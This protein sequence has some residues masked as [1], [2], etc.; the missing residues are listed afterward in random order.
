MTSY[1]FLDRFPV[2]ILHILFNYIPIPEL[3]YNLYNVSDYINAILIHYSISLINLKSFLQ[4]HVDFIC[5]HIKPDQIISLKLFDDIDNN[6]QS[7]LFFSH[8]HIEQFTQLQSLTLINIENTFLEFILPN[9]NRLNHLRSFSFDTTEDYR[10][11]NKDYRLRF[12]QCK[13][14]LLNT[15]T[16]LLSQLKQLTLYNVQ[17][18]TL[19][20]L[21]CLHHLKI[22]ECSTTELKRICSEIPQL[23][24]FN[25]CLQG[26][27]IYIKDLSSL[28][29]LTWLILKIDV[30]KNQFLSMNFIEE[31][32]PNLFQLKHFEFQ[33][34]YGDDFDDGKRWEKL[35]KSLITFNFKFKLRYL[36][37]SLNSF[38]TS[39]WLEEKHWFVVYHNGDL[40]TI[41]RFV[42]IQLNINIPLSIM[43][44]SSNHTIF[45]ENITKL[46]VST[47]IFNENH[48]F[49]NVKILKMNC[50]VSIEKLSHIINLNEI[51]HL[52]LSSQN[53]VRM[54]L[55]ILPVMP[56]FNELTITGY[57]VPV[58]IQELQNNI[59]K[60]IRI[61]NLRFCYFEKESISKTLCHIFPCIEY[62]NV[63]LINSTE[64][65]VFFTKQLKYLLN[66]SFGMNS[67]FKKDKNKNCQELQMS[68]DKKYTCQ[69]VHS[70][71][72]NTLSFVHIWNTEHFEGMARICLFDLL[73]IELLQ[74][75]FSYFLA[76]EIFLSFIDVSDYVNA[77]LLSY[78]AYQLDLKLIE[79]SQLNSFFYC[80]RPEQIISLT[81]SHD[82]DTSHLSIYFLSIFRLEQF[83]RL[84]SITFIDIKYEL[85][86]SIFNNLHKLSQLRSLSF[87][88]ENIKYKY[89]IFNIDFPAKLNQLN[90]FLFSVFVQILPHL[91]RVHL[92]NG[93]LLKSISLPHLHHLKLKKCSLNQL[94]AIF[95]HTPQLK[96]LDVCLRFEN[97][98]SQIV[99]SSVQLIRLNLTI[100]NYSVSINQLEQ[101]LLNLPYLKHFEVNANGRN[102][103]DGQQWQILTR[104]LI[105]F[106]FKFNTNLDLNERTLHSFRTPYWLE[107]KHW[108]VAYQNNCLFT[109]SR[110]ASIHM[111]IS[112]STYVYTTAPNITYV[113]ESITKL[114][115]EAI[116]T[117]N[118]IRYTHIEILNLQCSIS[119]EELISIIDLRQVKH[120]FILSLVDLLKLMPFEQLLPRICKL[121]ILNDLTMDMIKQIRYY[122][123]EQI[124]E[125]DISL[126]YENKNY[127]MKKIVYV[128]PFIE[129]ISYRNYL[130]S[131][132]DMF[133]FIYGFEHLR[134]TYFYTYLIFPNIARNIYRNPEFPIDISW[135]FVED[136]DFL[137]HIFSS[138]NCRQINRSIKVSVR[139]TFTIEILIC[140]HLFIIF[141]CCNQ[142][143]I[144]IGYNN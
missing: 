122:Q 132:Q 130:H 24:S 101:L 39:F 123:F 65:I 19:K 144:F 103:A 68:I 51:K 120:L 70:L 115:I 98:F 43:S 128:F 45:Y 44:N 114:T 31:F 82:N 141:R 72:Y 12:T 95:Q 32:L 109:V 100:E 85:I 106:N 9:L 131:I 40:Y 78:A 84:R 136:N 92:N 2:E 75:I 108:F 58:L 38:R 17:E 102:L 94:E 23:K 25:A 127:I 112:S 110:I 138:S 69:I 30:F 27:P 55:L 86:E 8:F 20:S 41:P 83:I 11:I 18:M 133:R 37:E 91:K 80:I 21:S 33:A 104:N 126:N 97:Q 52:I 50:L 48:Y 118:Q 135:Q 15:C 29:N 67:L 77:T 105:T 49:P 1:C 64:D 134:S 35:T 47:E 121:T 117:Q 111:I 124:R 74:M 119:H 89:E 57:L 22:S 87:D 3:Y 79:K 63:S 61:L 116:P 62:L 13:S 42:P 73:P 6:G 90:S 76:H 4:Y 88:I 26:D 140:R 99:L 81:L 113:N 107:E 137:Y 139:L 143:K 7:E 129:R 54:F 96:S 5:H 59:I 36:F 14:I 46:I 60:Q 142:L 16:N 56:L 53:S 66:A 71:N 125:L 10:M 93:D 28:S 34:N